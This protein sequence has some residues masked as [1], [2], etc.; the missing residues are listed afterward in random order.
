MTNEEFIDALIKRHGKEVYNKLINSKVAIAG[1]GGLGSNVAIALARAGV[2]EIFMVDFDNVDISNLNRQQYFISD[3][4]KAKTSALS[5][6]IRAVNPIIK[7][8]TVMIESVIIK[9]LFF[10]PIISFSSHL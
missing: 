4:G 8:K 3:I 1:L 6:K 2:G 5:E 10:L 7:I 9:I